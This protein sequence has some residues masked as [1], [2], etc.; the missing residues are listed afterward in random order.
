MKSLASIVNGGPRPPNRIR[1]RRYH[2]SRGRV[3]EGSGVAVS[4][5][6]RDLPE[7]SRSG[8]YGSPDRHDRHAGQRQ[9]AG[10]RGVSRALIDDQLVRRR[11]ASARAERPSG[12][13]DESGTERNTRVSVPRPH[14]GDRGILRV[15]AGKTAPAI[16]G[17][18]S[19]P[20]S[21]RLDAAAPRLLGP[22][23]NL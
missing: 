10:A 13:G 8:P 1:A 18:R 19:V 5:T 11:R 16:A 17:H 22:T 2:G 9:P 23:S 6:S 7:G 21:I 12:R 20:S 4:N 14:R 3:F 15:G